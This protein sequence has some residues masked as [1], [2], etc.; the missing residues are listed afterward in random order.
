MWAL[1]LEEL[2]LKKITDSSQDFQV[3][4]ETLQNIE[5]EIL[6]SAL[7]LS[8]SINADNEALFLQN[9][10][11]LSLDLSIPIEQLPQSFSDYQLQADFIEEQYLRVS[12]ENFTKTEKSQQSIIEYASKLEI[13][14][15]TLL[16]QEKLL[17]ELYKT[18]GRSVGV[19]IAI[20][21]SIFLISQLIQWAINARPHLIEEKKNV[22]MNVVKW[23]SN[24]SIIVII[25]VF[26]FS[27]LLSFLPFLAILWTA[28][29]FALR[30]IISSFIAWFLIW[31]KDSVYKIGDVIEVEW[32][33]V[34][35]RVFK[36]SPV[37]TTIQELWLSGPSGMYKSF[38]NKAVFEKSIKNISKINNWIYITV[39]FL[40]DKKS[41]IPKAKTLLLEVMN[42]VIN[43]EK[44]S[45]PFEARAPF[46][47]YGITE[48]NMHPQIFLDIKPQGIFLRGK[49]F[50]YWA[51]R[52]D[53]RS[54]IVEMF[55]N[56]AQKD[57]SIEVKQVEIG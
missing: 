21:V 38:P 37:V 40:L 17:S 56:N 35:G 43:H 33:N 11:A 2:N 10:E 28:I 1:S 4:Y 49:I 3:K 14:N 41:S 13:A 16:R 51:E 26:F 50:V 54:E 12:Q 18:L 5:S 29:G 47:K 25:A 55:F 24:I 57:D 36:I 48:A 20:V 8:G 9:L 15:S 30:D 32:D 7:Y 34:F 42:E 46:R 53:I 31:H 39:D 19:L 52:H 44:Y 23:T 45:S 27:E 6:S 22:L